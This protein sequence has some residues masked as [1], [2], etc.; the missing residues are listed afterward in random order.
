MIS[1]S[2]QELEP[3]G[4]AGRL[5]HP[6]DAAREVAALRGGGGRRPQLPRARA[7]RGAGGAGSDM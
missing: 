2:S 1:R 3:L 7:E 6:A 5:D 4:T